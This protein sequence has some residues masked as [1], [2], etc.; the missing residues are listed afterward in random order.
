MTVCSA[1]HYTQVLPVKRWHSW[2][3]I[4]LPL[5][6]ILATIIFCITMLI[7]K[8]GVSHTIGTNHPHVPRKLHMKFCFNRVSGL[9]PYI[10]TSLFIQLKKLPQGVI[11]DNQF[12]FLNLF[13]Q[14]WLT[15]NSN[16][17]TQNKT[18]MSLGILKKIFSS[19]DITHLI[20]LRESGKM[21]SAKKSDLTC[22]LT[23]I[24]ITNLLNHM[25]TNGKQ[26]P[27]IL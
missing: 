7:S 26:R 3:Y 21:W 23:F 4:T 27:V 6:N 18:K 14:A 17:F 9:M 8:R 1:D 20:V 13:V 12:H 10:E 11:S 15:G 2:V 19:S 16:I 25:Q 24:Q 5:L 22:K